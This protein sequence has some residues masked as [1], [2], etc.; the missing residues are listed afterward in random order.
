[1]RVQMRDFDCGALC[2]LVER[3]HY[4]LTAIQKCSG[5]QPGKRKLNLNKIAQLEPPNNG[6][7][8][9]EVH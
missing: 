9:E 5:E 6:K 2:A 7:I 4:F 3:R 8:I 1:V